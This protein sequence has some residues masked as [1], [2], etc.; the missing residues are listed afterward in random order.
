MTVVVPLG[1]V[2]Q[3]IN[4]LIIM[5]II[6][7]IIIIIIIITITTIITIV[8]CLESIILPIIIEN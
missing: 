5:I 2:S 8:M 1:A 7:V 3:E 6:I 4:F